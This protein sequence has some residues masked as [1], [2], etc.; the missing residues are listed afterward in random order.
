MSFQVGGKIRIKPGLVGAGQ[1]GIIEKIK[2]WNLDS[3]WADIRDNYH[4]CVM[5]D[6]YRYHFHASQIEEVGDE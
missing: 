5:E 4:W 2:P 6:G 3:R 1:I